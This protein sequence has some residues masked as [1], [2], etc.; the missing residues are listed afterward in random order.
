MSKRPFL[1]TSFELFADGSL[2]PFS[3][4]L[5]FFRFSEYRFE[6]NAS[7]KLAGKGVLYT[8]LEPKEG[9]RLHLFNTHLQASY[10]DTV[11]SAPPLP[12]YLPPPPTFCAID[13]R[14]NAIEGS[15][16]AADGRLHP[17]NLRSNQGKR[18]RN[19]PPLRSPPPILFLHRFLLL[20]SG[21]I[22][23]FFWNR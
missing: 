2:P 4:S 7:D 10:G 5:S 15:S 20:L 6:G 14:I 9:V 1:A 23:P 8:L 18:N 13:D 17:K 12:P 19:Y 16:S 3:C 11:P 21:L 22:N